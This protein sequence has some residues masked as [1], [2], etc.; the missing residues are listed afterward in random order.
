MKDETLHKG[1]H[2]QSISY[3]PTVTM[4]NNT[5][6]AHAKAIKTQQSKSNHEK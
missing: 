4:I 6:K 1:F 5:A 3:F 2:E